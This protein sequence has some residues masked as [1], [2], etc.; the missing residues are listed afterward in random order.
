MRGLALWSFV[1]AAAVV[2]WSA[3]VIKKHFDIEQTA[4]LVI[5][6]SQQRDASYVVNALCRD[7]EAK[8]RSGNYARCAEAEMDASA[9]VDAVCFAEAFWST[10]ETVL[11]RTLGVFEPKTWQRGVAWGLG[12]LVVAMCVS[13]YAALRQRLLEQRYASERLSDAM[14]YRQQCV[15]DFTKTTPRIADADYDVTSDDE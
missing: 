9:D 3:N 11:S 7:Y 5:K 13:G 14:M 2:A 12:A 1:V 15:L 10:F 8:G 4:C 6:R